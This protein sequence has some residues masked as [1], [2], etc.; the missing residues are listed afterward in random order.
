M[1]TGAAPARID[2]R[3]DLRTGR[4]YSRLLLELSQLHSMPMGNHDQSLISLAIARAPEWIRRELLSD[5]KAI[6]ARAEEAL[7]AMIA[8]A[9]QRAV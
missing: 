6:R 2:D 7:A 8:N 4:F 3:P 5:E 1:H 9:L